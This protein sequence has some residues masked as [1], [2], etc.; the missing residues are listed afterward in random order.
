M[1]VEGLAAEAPMKKVDH[2]RINTA[3][4]VRTYAEISEEKGV[5]DMELLCI[6]K[7]YE[8][9]WFFA[10]KKGFIEIGIQ[11]TSVTKHGQKTVSANLS[12]VKNL[13]KKHE[14]VRIYHTHPWSI[15]D[16]FSDLTPVT[17]H[18]TSTENI[19][20]RV[21][22][23]NALPSE[24]DLGGMMTYSLIHR[25]LHPKGSLSCRIVSGQGLTSYGL[26]SIGREELRFA[27]ADQIASLCE[28]S[29]R[30]AVKVKAGNGEAK[31][32]KKACIMMSS[33]YIDVTFKKLKLIM[34]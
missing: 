24:Q 34:P 3:N 15:L 7:E 12:Y 32:I 11:E 28:E 2:L 20:G 23:N 27:S 29:V 9:A 18:A 16:V 6:N 26:T 5:Q 4:Q 22:R 25:E 8:E 10:P 14:H 30:T 13:L 19:M 17:I 21:F 1:G 33:E 31:D